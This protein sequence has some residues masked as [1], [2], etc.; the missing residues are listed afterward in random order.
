MVIK[1]ASMTIYAKT[2]GRYEPNV[3]ALATCGGPTGDDVSV[4]KTLRDQ[5][6]GG[7]MK[8]PLSTHHLGVHSNAPLAAPARDPCERAA[9]A[10][11]A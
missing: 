7:I 6:L 3:R 10:F 5:A 8:K 4:V 9:F 1:I 11:G 2:A